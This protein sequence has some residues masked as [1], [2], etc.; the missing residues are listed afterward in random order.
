MERTSKEYILPIS[1]YKVRVYD[2]YLRGDRVAI[3]RIMTDAVEMTGEGVISSVKTSYR[4]DMEDEAVIR[5]IASI[6]SEQ[7]ADIEVS[8]DNIR[9]LSEDDY[10]FLRTKLPKENEKKSTTKPSEDISA[11]P[12][13]SEE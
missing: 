13:K 1:K 7:G 2:Y 9:G 5:A 10:K 11:I 8:V 4:F 12:L 3:E 6:K